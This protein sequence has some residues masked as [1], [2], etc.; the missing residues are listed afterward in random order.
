MRARVET[1]ARKLGYRP[2]R[3]ASRLANE[4]TGLV[5]LVVHD[6]ANPGLLVLMETFTWRLQ[7]KVYD[8]I[9]RTL[10]KRRGRTQDLR[11]AP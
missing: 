4:R 5:G 9:Y 8:P 10:T 2:N 11:P 1:E 7:Q 3:P 6:F